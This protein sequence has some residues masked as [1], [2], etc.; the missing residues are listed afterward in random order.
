[1]IHGFTVP[2]GME[3]GMR[4]RGFT[5]GMFDW[6]RR[7]PWGDPGFSSLVFS[8]VVFGFVGGITGVTIGTEQ[9][10]IIVAQHA[11][12]PRPLPRDGRGR[13][14]ARL[15]GARATTSAAHLP[16]P[17]LWPRLATP[18]S[19]SSAIGI[20]L[21]AGGMTT[22]GSYAVPR[23]H[24]GCPVRLVDLPAARRPA[25]FFFLGLIGDGG[26]SGRGGGVLYVLDHRRRRCSSRSSACPT[27]RERS[28]FAATTPAGRQAHADLRDD[29][30]GVRIPG[31]VRHLLL[32][33]LE[34]AVRDLVPCGDLVDDAFDGPAG[35]SSRPPG[36]CERDSAA[37]ARG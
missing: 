21:F 13:H 36:E 10:N 28:R 37:E 31:R 19:T 5:E 26:L 29:H 25:A 6:L 20:A 8:V 3:L 23:R 15:H 11:A 32:P 35:S 9:I 22:A 27:R 33:Q 17:D 34:V 2:A 12:R 4:L 30:P 7:A 16:A 14:L 1:M 18:R 24:S